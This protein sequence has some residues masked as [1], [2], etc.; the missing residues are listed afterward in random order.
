MFPL[1]TPAFIEAAYRNG[2]FPMADCDGTI[3]WYH[4]DPRGIFDLGLFHVSRRL[5]RIVRQGRFEIKLD[6]DFEG[7]IHACAEREETWIS[8]EIIKAYGE[9][10]RIGK[11]HSV[12]AYLN[13][14]MVGGIYGV[15]LGGAFMAESMF[16]HEK[17]ASSVCLIYL[18]EHLRRQGYSFLE[19]QYLTPHLQR[20]GA[21]EIPKGEYLQRLQWALVA[22]C[23][24]G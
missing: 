7:V 24:W 14:C 17:A 9:M 16:S 15:S 5:S 2:F 11:A 23:Q 20:F 21:V 12:E 13:G 1:L 4:P 8:Q 19:V 22:D 18:V 10:H 3:G 6:H